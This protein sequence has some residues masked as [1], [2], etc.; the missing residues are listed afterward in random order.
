MQKTLS[1]DTLAAWLRLSLQPGIGSIHAHRLLQH[2]KDPCALY[3]ASYATL[4]AMLSAPLA[5]QLTQPL[6]SADAQAIEHAL[7]WASELGRA[8]VTP[9]HRYYP[10]RLRHT[11]DAPLVLY[12]QGALR[13]LEQ[14]ALALVGAR[15]A[16][17]DGLAHAQAF[18]THLAQQGFAIVSGL[19]HGIDAAAHRGALKAGRDAG[20]TIAV[21]GTGA[22]LIYP[23]AHQS[24]ADDIL[25]NDG[26][27]L[28]EFGLGCPALAANFPKRNRIVAGLSLGVIVVEAALKSGSLI[29]A[30]LAVELGREVYALPGS[31]HSPL[32]R[33]PHALIKQGAKLV[34]SGADILAELLPNA[35]RAHAS[36]LPELAGADLA[37]ADRVPESPVWGA[38]GY[39][40]VTEEQLQRRTGLPAATLQVELF[41][42][43][44]E[45]H[46]ERRG[47]GQF[48]RTRARS[49]T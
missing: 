44:L 25:T 16:T 17:A 3:R 29:T 47:H 1:D 41:T 4:K 39:D 42:L 38:I 9:G 31:L 33:G 5:A 27:I 37:S 15:N 22:D 21:L 28:S 34:E 7:R 6:S 49:A 45:G 48:V 13:R 32:S 43:E 26:L 10:E 18:A 30:R 46:I 40:L 11:P 8:L 14:D 36:A 24:L 23:T 12:T 20:G 19:A 2:F 35:G